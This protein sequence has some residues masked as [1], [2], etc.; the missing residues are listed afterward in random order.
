MYS[1]T[2]TA[3]P[4][5]GGVALLGLSVLG[6]LWVGVTLICLGTVIFGLIRLK[7]AEQ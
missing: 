5:T 4:A 2:G 7:L 3:L 6:P 1:L